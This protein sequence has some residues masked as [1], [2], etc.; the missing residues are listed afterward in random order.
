MPLLA[1]GDS[2]TEL[3][4]SPD[5]VA[6]LIRDLEVNPPAHLAGFVWFRLPTRDDE[7][8]WSIATWR[9]VIKGQ[10][11]PAAIE[12]HSRPS[13]TPG[14]SLL[15]LANTGDL[16]GSLPQRIELPAS[17]RIGDG[18][19]GYSTVSDY[20]NITL[21]RRGSGLLR[22]HQERVIG[23]MRCAPAPREIHVQP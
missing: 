21:Q 11:E 16:D 10:P 4:A 1:G 2:S 14:M 18:A 20:T 13:D 6:A 22:G 19:N 17:C 8:A 12:A 23:W 7:R 15:V 5:E 9:A 3:M